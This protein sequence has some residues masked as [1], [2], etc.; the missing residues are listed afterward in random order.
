[1]KASQGKCVFFIMT[2]KFLNKN[3]PFEL[4]TN[5]GFALGKN[6]LRGWEYLSEAHGNRLNSY[7]FIQA[8]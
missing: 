5:E 2:E 7:P 1:M 4:L 3:F 6:F 8:M